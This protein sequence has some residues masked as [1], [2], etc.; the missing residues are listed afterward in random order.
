MVILSFIEVNHA[1]VIGIDV[2]RLVIGEP[3]L[4]ASPRYPSKVGVGLCLHAVV[5]PPVLVLI[6]WRKQ[7]K[8]NSDGQIIKIMACVAIGRSTYIV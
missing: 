8:H 7:I 1:V 2:V 5:I 3:F 6:T 4:V